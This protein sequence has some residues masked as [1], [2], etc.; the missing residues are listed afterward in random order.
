MKRTTYILSAV[1]VLFMSASCTKEQQSAGDASSDEIRIE[2]SLA[3]DTKASSLV[4][5]LTTRRIHLDGYIN[6]DG[7]HPSNNKHLDANALYENSKWLFY[8]GIRDVHYYWPQTSHLDFFA[9][10]PADLSKTCCAVER[11]SGFQNKIICTDLPMVDTAKAALELQ[12]F[13]CVEKKNSQKTDAA[14]DL[15]FKRPFSVVQFKLDSAVRSDLNFIRITG[16][17]NS[18]NL[19]CSKIPWAWN[20]SGSTTDFTCIVNKNYPT[21]INN[22]SDLGGPFIM[23][24]QSLLKDGASPVYMEFNYQTVGN[25]TPTTTFLKLGTS[26]GSSGTV[27]EWKAGFNYTYYISLMGAAGEVKMSVK[28]EVWD[29]QGNSE[30]IVQ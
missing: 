22:D 7:N 18:G 13:V 21:E 19:Y 16:I 5:D 11:T 14:V 25:D 15:Q 1:V 30:I 8:T 3:E 23:I 4:T 27:N 9:Y 12:E 24:P 26:T 10:S 6:S 28:C 17:Y 2:A 20:V 29:P